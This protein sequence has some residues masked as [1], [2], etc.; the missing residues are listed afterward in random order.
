MSR[1]MLMHMCVVVVV[2]VCDVFDV[3]AYVCGGGSCVCDVWWCRHVGACVCMW[4]LCVYACV[5]C[6]GGVWVG[7][8]CECVRV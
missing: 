6:V 8:V 5:M 4:C 2:C 7:G 1:L 3:N